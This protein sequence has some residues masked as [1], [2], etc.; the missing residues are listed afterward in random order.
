MKKTA[1]RQA[2]P[3]LLNYRSYT[4]LPAKIDPAGKI[5][6][7]M[8]GTPGVIGWTA[9]LLDHGEYICMGFP[10]HAKERQAIQ[11]L[12]EKTRFLVR[13]DGNPSEPRFEFAL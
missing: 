3:V 2:G 8:P 7:A 4:V 5:V 12:W 13:L 11:D 9:F 6:P 10:I 1:R